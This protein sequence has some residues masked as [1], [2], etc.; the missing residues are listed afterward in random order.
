[1]RQ[2]ADS[3]LENGVKPEQI[4]FLNL[5]ILENETLHDYKALHE[6]V[7]SRLYP[8]GYSYIFIDEA[9]L[10]SSFEKTVNSLL[11]KEKTDIY[12]TG[13]NA[14]LLSGELATLLSGRYVLIEMLPLSFA[15]YLEFF[16]NVREPVSLQDLFRDYLSFGS[17]PGV[18][19]FAEQPDLVGTV[20]DGI[21]NTILIK[22]IAGRLNTVEISLVEKISNF[23]FDN[24]GSSVSVKKITD[25]ISSNGRK[26]SVNTV[27]RY[28]K[29]LVDSY[30]FYKADRFDLRGRQH[31]KTQSKYYAVDTG[32]RYNALHNNTPDLGH[33]LENIV[34]L[35]LR[36]RRHKVSIGK[37]GESEVDFVAGSNDGIQYFQVAASVLDENTLNRELL[38][39]KRI[40]DNHP[41]ILLTM[42]TIPHRGNYSG[43]RQF[44]IIDWLL[45]KE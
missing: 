38:P 4:I 39:L 13:S 40:P 20:L 28:I 25:T 10:C 15:E 6:Y 32:L 24:V 2:Y 7:S 12:I 41:K 3:L 14:Y 5:E 45:G 1:M 36:R 17:F 16:K 18:A 27:D 34:Y 42:D 9:Q 19:M 33:V 11:T 21:Y 37:L 31:L 35:E 30:L 29:V 8:D 22:D 43:I 23:L 44:N 26:I